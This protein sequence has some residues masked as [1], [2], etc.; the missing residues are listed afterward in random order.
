[1]CHGRGRWTV[2]V[3]GVCVG[4]SAAAG[5]S[6]LPVTAGLE[7][8]FDATAFSNRRP[9]FGVTEWRDTSGRQRHA[10]AG[11]GGA[12]YGEARTPAGLY[13]VSFHDVCDE[14]MSFCYNPNNQ[15]I[16]MIG[17]SRSRMEATNWP[18]YFHGFIGWPEVAGETPLALGAFN[19]TQTVI[20]LS[21][22][23]EEGISHSI[24]VAHVPATGFTV[25]TV[26]LN[27]ALGVLDVFRNKRPLGELLGIGQPIQGAASC[28][29]IGGMRACDGLGWAGDIAEIL[30]Y[31]RALTDAER[32]AV[33]SYL[34][35]KWLL[36]LKAY[37]PSPPDGAVDVLLGLPTWSPGHTA[38]QHE[39]YIGTTPHLGPEDLVFSGSFWPPVGFKPPAWKPQTTYFWRVDEV[40]S[41]RARVHTGN[42]WSFVTA[43]STAHGP[44][45]R[46]GA[47]FV[48]SN[49]AP[50]WQPG[51]HMVRHD[52]Y[53][54]ADRQQ[55]LDGAGGTFRGRQEAT[56]FDPGPLAEEAVYFWRIDEAAANAQI[57]R[58]PVWSFT[59]LGPGGGVKADY[60][61]NMSRYGKPAL[62]RVD[63]KVDFLW[64]DDSPDPAVDPDYFS[65]RWTG[66]LEPV[67][68]DIYTFMVR[69]NGYVTLW[70][71]NVKLIERRLLTP[72][73]VEDKGTM[74]LT[75]GKTY[76]IRMEYEVGKGQAV[77]QLFWQSP[78]MPRQIIPPGL[79]QPPVRARGPF[80]T[81]GAVETR[82]DLRLRWT[83]GWRATRHDMYFGQDAKEVAAATTEN[84]DVYLGRLPGHV[85][86]VRSGTL[87]WGQ[88]YYWRIDEVNEADAKGLW[89][90]NIWSF[91]TAD[92]IPVDDFES[93][94]D[95]D[96]DRIYETWI[97]GWING[98]GS[99]VGYVIAGSWPIRVRRG[100]QS[101]PFDYD[102]TRPPYY[103][104]TQRTWS[105]P[106][107]WTAHGA[108]EL[109][110]WFAGA[111]VSFRETPEGGVT[112]SGSGGEMECT[113]DPYRFVYRR[114]DGD[115]EIV[116]RIDSL[117]NAQGWARAGVLIADTPDTGSQYAIAAVTA[118]YGLLFGNCP[119]D[120]TAGV[121]TVQEGVSVPYW[122]RLTRTGN[123]LTAG[124]SQD[125][126]AWQDVTDANGL[127]MVIAMEL[128]QALYVGLC[129]SSHKWDVVTT[130]EFSQIAL[131]GG[132]SESW[133]VA[134]TELDQPGNSRDRLYV[135]LADTKGRLGIAVHP[136]P[137]AVNAADWTRWA[138]PLGDFAQAGVDLT[139][140]KSMSL[141]VGDRTRPKPDGAGMIYIDD[142]R[143]I[144]HP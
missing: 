144:A 128:P 122:V 107:D 28:G 90:G 41:N 136:D 108:D 23:G 132:V 103:S 31:S 127:P 1:M 68:S 65:V 109:S 89:K 8:R 113:Y 92:F 69:T 125:G 18:Y 4:L 36:A 60:F 64:G 20:A 134:Q 12:T 91:A 87:E 142:I 100:A 61:N 39:L 73:P 33:E 80:P 10:T 46:D 54:G 116:A 75:T 5:G 58:G 135:V 110:L 32:Q 22:Y 57:H 9:G 47:R 119:F 72:A 14:A 120:G 37:D 34:H 21:G 48:D 16:T 130:A 24:A 6:E 111:P 83:P 26:R 95:A 53:F 62:T 143:V 44:R 2:L 88:E 51:L 15:D 55:V 99:T 104:E 19:V 56:T 43:P 105:T 118:G 70:V 42:V 86:E 123:Q 49:T 67:F 85:T 79:L 139:A 29:Y 52:V 137:G 11:N 30:V 45:P 94:S 133:E 40:E 124:H 138:I 82:H 140:I 74:A 81:D 106:Q 7:L 121:R 78:A 76:P 38:R 3:F 25:N 131:T 101:M 63:P 77:I 129:V 59:T 126:L 13:T 27:S 112:I 35:G 115:G 93:Y 98:T 71:D 96:G 117:T 84:A 114:L 50:S 141:G 102:N 97:D 17:V 66:D